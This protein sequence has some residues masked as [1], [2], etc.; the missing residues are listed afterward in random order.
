M[1]AG[2]HP[3]IRPAIPAFG[4]AV[5][6]NLRL[7]RRKEDRPLAKAHLITDDLTPDRLRRFPR[8]SH[9]TDEMALEVI[10]SLRQ[11]ASIALDIFRPN[12][13]PVK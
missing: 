12:S 11:L 6:L 3:T 4:L 5:L 2:W 9:L 10:Q 7:N 13:I 8:L 1:N